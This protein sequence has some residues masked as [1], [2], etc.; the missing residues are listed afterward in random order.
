MLYTFLR[1]WPEGSHNLK[2]YVTMH[3]VTLHILVVKAYFR[4]YHI[5][6]LYSMRNRAN[7]KLVWLL[8]T[9]VYDAGKCYPFCRGGIIISLFHLW[10]I[11]AKFATTMQDIFKVHQWYKCY[12]SNQPTFI[13][14]NTH[15]MRCNQYLI[16][17]MSPKTWD[18]TAHGP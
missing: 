15:L 17:L 2:T 13:A 12:C 18:W 1:H 11:Q 8:Q 3:F 10:N 4:R 9:S 5:L 7:A 14:I 16:L 6:I